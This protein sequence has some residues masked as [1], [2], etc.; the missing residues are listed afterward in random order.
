MRCRGAV[1][2]AGT[3]DGAMLHPTVLTDVTDTMPLMAEEMFAPVVCLVPCSDFTDAIAAVN[4]TPFGLSAG[5][6]TRDIDRAF[7]AARQV[8]VGL[9]NINN[10]SSNRADPMPYGGC[11]A[12]G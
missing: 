9:F 6:F 7:A 4:G 10:T 11:S 8:T 2:L 12:S 5:I 3:C 1:V